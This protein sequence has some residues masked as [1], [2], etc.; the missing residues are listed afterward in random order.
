MKGKNSERPII[1][2]VAKKST[3]SSRASTV[4]LLKF[5]P[6]TTECDRQFCFQV[7]AMFSSDSKDSEEGSS[8]HCSKPIL[9]FKVRRLS[10]N[11][12][13]LLSPWTSFK[14]AKEGVEHF[15][16]ITRN[17]CPKEERPEK[18][19]GEVCERFYL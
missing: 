2:K 7:I 15:A 4:G 1:T 3:Q 18:I 13:G 6:L 11:V 9:C 19:L 8:S 10:S 5:T 12:F 16:R 14:E 17:T